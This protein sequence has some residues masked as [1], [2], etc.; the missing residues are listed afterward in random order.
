MKKS[1]TSINLR[2]R[3]GSESGNLY[4]ASLVR[5]CVYCIDKVFI[6]RHKYCSVVT[7]GER[8]HVDGDLNIEI[9]FSAVIKRLSV[10]FE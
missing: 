2:C 3:V 6:T 5:Y 8:Q 10:L 1:A 7:A 4:A 9:A